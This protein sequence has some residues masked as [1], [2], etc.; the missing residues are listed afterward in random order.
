MIV[1]TL[2]VVYS[3]LC[4]VLSTVNGYLIIVSNAT[5]PDT[6]IFD[7]MLLNFKEPSRKYYMNVDKSASFVEKLVQV[8]PFTGAVTLKRYLACDG[9]E[10]PNIFTLYIDSS[11]NEIYEYVSIPL[12]VYIR[13]CES[14]GRIKGTLARINNCRKQ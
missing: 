4:L 6:Q 5:E 11:S 3:L 7:G 12:K 10:Y 13:G 1:V 9:I 8:N 2:Y 14:G